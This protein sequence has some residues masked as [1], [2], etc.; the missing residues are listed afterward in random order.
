MTESPFSQDF[1]SAR[2]LFRKAAA[3]AGAQLE[4]HSYPIPGP[5][6]EDLST[7]VAWIGPPD[8]KK[9]LVTVSGTHGVEGFCGSAAQVDWL[10]RGEA[11]RLPASTAAMLVHAINPFGFR[12]APTSHAREC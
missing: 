11:A 4:S 3:T 7:E 1:V 10:N 5:R 2:T 9:V 8:A 12:L 6:G